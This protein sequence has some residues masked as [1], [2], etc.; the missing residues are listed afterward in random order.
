[1][2]QYTIMELSL[3]E[4]CTLNCGYCWYAEQGKVKDTNQLKKFHDRS[5]I[6]IILKFFRQ[7]TTESDRWHLCLT[8]GE[9]LLMPN[10]DY[11]SEEIFHSGN[12]VSFY[13]NFSLPLSHPNMKWFLKDNSLETV[14]YLMCS[15]HPESWPTIDD[16]FFRMKVLK[17]KGHNIICRFVGHPKLLHKMDELEQRCSKIGITFFPTYFSSRNYPAAYSSQE[18]DLFITHMKDIASLMQLEGG[19]DVSQRKCLAGTK[20]FGSYL[21]TGNITPCISVHQPIIGNI[22]ENV[23][24]PFNNPVNCMR[25][26]NIC[27]CDVHVQQ[28]MI[29]GIDDYDRFQSIKE[30]KS[31]PVGKELWEKKKKE[32]KL[33]FG[34]SFMEIGGVEDDTILVYEK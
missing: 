16:Y 21:E 33:T 9:P 6:D 18:R 8:G 7:R 22:Y 34:R 29:V 32:L 23:L 26:D 14:D 30:G 20:L 24:D 5:Y 2:V 25:E 4:T 15:V 12:K 28:N 19:L 3:F 27:A 10:L 1:M 31:S 11:F 13:T 17:E